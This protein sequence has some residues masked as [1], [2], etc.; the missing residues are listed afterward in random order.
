[1]IDLDY[2]RVIES[3][4]SKVFVGTSSRIEDLVELSLAV[5]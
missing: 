2:N 5:E 3:G 4:K 1:M